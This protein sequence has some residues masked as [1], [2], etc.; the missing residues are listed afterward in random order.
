[1][2]IPILDTH[3]HLIYPE[4]WPYSWTRDIAELTG[5]PFH[6]DHYL[7]AIEGTGIAAT[8]FMESTPD[9][10]Y[11]QEETRFVEN[12]SRQPDTLIRGLIANCRP[13]DKDGFVPY[14][15]SILSDRLVGLRRFLHAVPDETSEPAHFVENIR[16]LAPHHL[17]FDLCVF[18]RQ[19]P[20]ALRIAKACPEVQFILDHCGVPAIADGA[21]D[22]WRAG[23]RELAALPNV[24]C[25]ISG[26]LAYC[27][28]GQ[29]N[30]ETVRPYV[31]HCIE[32]FGWDRVV[33]GGDWPV[34]T[35]TSTLRDW[36]AVS[37]ELVRGES[38]EHQ[39]K[40]FHLNAERIYRVA[41]NP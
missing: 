20:I 3:Q 36:V 34:V 24:A 17:T 14:L 19:L 26:V 28:P 2:S 18:A 13:E 41:L 33:W 11:W 16:R 9:D 8:V 29:A 30:T 6:Y 35:L 15:E 23:I 22:P 4:R 10:P 31:E 1:V 21:M 40:L 7:D 39:H 25:K 12:L 5:K 37:R 38:E 27:K 32:S